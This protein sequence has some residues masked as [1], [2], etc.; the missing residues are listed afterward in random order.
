MD[1]N[2]REQTLHVDSVFYGTHMLNMQQS[3]LQSQHGMVHIDNR[4][5]RFHIHYDLNTEMSFLFNPVSVKPNQEMHLTLDAI[6]V[7]NLEH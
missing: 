4:W 3:M 2:D 6:V 7:L 5:I 1:S